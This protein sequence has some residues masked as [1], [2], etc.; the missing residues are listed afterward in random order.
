MEMYGGRLSVE[1]TPDKGTAVTLY[2]PTIR[3]IGFPDPGGS[4]VAAQ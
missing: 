3:V 4:E 2:V 1:S